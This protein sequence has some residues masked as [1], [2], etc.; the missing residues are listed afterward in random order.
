MTFRLTTRRV[1][2]RGSALALLGLIAL[3]GPALA[4]DAA[5]PAPAAAAPA[6]APAPIDP[7]TVVATINGSPITEADL[8]LAAQD[9]SE[10]LAKVPADQRRKSVLD[11]LIDLK[12]M[13]NAAEGAGLDKSDE[14][15]RRLTLLR[16]RA[17]RN[18][19]FRSQVDEKITD[20]AVRKRYDA[21]IAK[22]APQE[23]IQAS[24]ILVETEDEAKAIIKQLDAGGDFAAIAKEKS[25]DPGSAK[26]GGDLGYFSQGKMV[27]EFEKAAFA[28]EVGK[29]TETPVKTQYGYHVIK[30]TDKRKQP[31][32]TY[33]Q[34]KDQVRQ[35]VLRDTFV[36]AVTTLR[37]ENK[38]EIIDPTLKSDTP[39]QPAK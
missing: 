17:L 6:A 16:E 38:V 36:N 39:A 25:K 11:V 21:E 26:M 20:E 27:P 9:F 22:V 2:L 18:E 19:F 32:P 10:E 4:Q 14:F 7:K 13:A 23:E 30:V 24:H 1:G 15:Q 31:L 28:L 37:K 12:L 29:Y 33:D 35:L 34:V 5:T 3:A 8:D